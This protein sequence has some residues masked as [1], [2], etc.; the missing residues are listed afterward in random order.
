MGERMDLALN[1]RDL[2]QASSRI[3]LSR[4]RSARDFGCGFSCRECSDVGLR[5]VA[6]S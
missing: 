5:Q 6:A 3:I 1:C 2:L 4:N